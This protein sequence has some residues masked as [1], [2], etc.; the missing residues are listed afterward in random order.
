MDSYVK[1]SAEFRNPFLAKICWCVFS[2][3]AAQSDGPSSF[4]ETSI[5][6]YVSTGKGII[7]GGDSWQQVMSDLDQKNVLIIISN[8]ELIALQKTFISAIERNMYLVNWCTEKSF[9]LRQWSARCAIFFQY[10]L[11]DYQISQDTCDSCIRVAKIP[12]IF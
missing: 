4:S 10:E 6:A 5:L 2:N 11:L 8:K 1:M 12:I 9:Q 3:M 7:L